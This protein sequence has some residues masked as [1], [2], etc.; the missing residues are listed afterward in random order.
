MKFRKFIRALAITCT[1]S[2]SLAAYAVDPYTITD[3]GTLGGTYSYANDINAA[4]Q[5]VGFAFTAGDAAQHAF[6]WS[7]GTMTDLGTLGGT[8]SSGYGINT[9]GQV[10][11]AADIAGPE[12]H[13]F[14]RSSSGTMIDI[15][16]LGGSW[17]AAFDI[18]TSG[19]VVGDAY[20]AGDAAVHAFLRSSSGTM[21]DLGTLGGTSSDGYGINTAGQVVGAADTARDAATHAFLWSGG[22]MTDLNSLLP[23]NSGWELAAASAINDAGQIVGY[24]YIGVDTHAFLM[25]PVPVPAAAWLFISGLAGLFGFVRRCTKA[26]T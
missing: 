17:G 13:A 10:V 24:G 12:T 7:G 18:N 2:N 21:T 23:A 14:L 26:K 3:L 5:V 4:G 20:T 15:G 19:Q 6:L 16:T 22:T 1:V 9:S 25:T 11:G 8:N